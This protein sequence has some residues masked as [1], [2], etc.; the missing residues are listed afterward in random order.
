MKVLYTDVDGTL[1][2]PLGNLLWDGARNPT[3]VAAEALVRAARE[4][5]EIVAVTGRARLG[6]AEVTRL[7][8][9]AT[10]FCELGSVRVYDRGEHI[11]HDHGAY[12]G[13]GAPGD[14]LAEARALL[15]GHF[16]GRIE[17]HAPWNTTREASVLLRGDV[18][19]GDA[20][21]ILDGAGFGWAELVDN[22]VIPRRF[23]TLA[24]LDRVRV[25]H[26]VP[27]G[28][29]KANAIAADRALRGLRREEC[30]VVGDA[31]A[32]LDCRLEVG[33]C[34]LV[35]NALAKDP[36]LGWATEPGSGVEVLRGGHGA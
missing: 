5:L 21:A 34:F 31:A 24:A 15:M 18:D 19:P 17:E 32:D 10:W 2:G 13:D 30:A 36:S 16:P 3:A 20:D 8:G 25:Y 12:P 27:R 1:V 35:A 26:L 33:R 6:M 14:A 7:L 11:V 22:G 23:E 28:V 9:L 4:G 29:S